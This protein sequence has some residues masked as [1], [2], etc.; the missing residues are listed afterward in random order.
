LICCNASI[1][2]EDDRI[3]KIRGQSRFFAKFGVRA[4]FGEISL[5][6]K[7]NRNGAAFM[8]GAA[9]EEAADSLTA[10][11]RNCLKMCSDPEF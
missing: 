6:G 8:P 11:M 9:D 5:A 3:L 1:W 4:L 10:S 2:N 7:A